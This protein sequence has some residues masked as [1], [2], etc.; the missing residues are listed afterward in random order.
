[1]LELAL[2]E[3][4]VQSFQVVAHRLAAYLPLCKPFLFD[5]GSLFGQRKFLGG[6]RLFKRVTVAGYDTLLIVSV[7]YCIKLGLKSANLR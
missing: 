4:Q 5:L 1:M 6:R 3:S 2:T 7:D